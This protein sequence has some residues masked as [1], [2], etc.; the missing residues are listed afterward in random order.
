[1]SEILLDRISLRGNG[2][3]DVVVL[4]RSAA[5][6]PAPASALVRLDARGAGES[7]SFPATITPD[8][9]GQWSVACTIPP[10]GPQFADGADILDGFAEVIFGDELVATR[11][12]WGTTDRMWLPYPTASR[13]LSL[14]QVKG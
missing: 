5:G 8:G 2:E 11:L 14:T 1:M 13:K 12:G 10:G 9:P 7:R 6:G 4:A 3:M